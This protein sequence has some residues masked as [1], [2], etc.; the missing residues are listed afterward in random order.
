MPLLTQ[1][2]VK[3]IIL[4]YIGGSKI[5]G[6]GAGLVA[7]AGREVIVKS[8]PLFSLIDK[9]RGIV[10][11]A[12]VFRDTLLKN[13]QSAAIASTVGFISDLKTK[14]NNP[15]ISPAIQTQLLTKLAA[16]E[17]EV[18]NFQLHTDIL[19]GTTIPNVFEPLE[20]S[21]TDA[22]TATANALAYSISANS[23]A[24]SAAASSLLAAGFANVATSESSSASGY[25]YSSSLSAASANTSAVSANNSSVI[26]ASFATNANTSAG[27]SNTSANAAALSATQASANATSSQASANNSLNSSYSANTS[28]AQSA[29]NAV[30]SQTSATNA[31]TSA[32]NSATSSTQAATFAN[33]A[34]TSAG[35]AAS[36][37]TA[38]ATSASQA[39]ANATS[40]NASAN[41]SLNSSLAA[42]TSAGN[43]ATSATQSAANA[44]SSQTSSTNANT[45]AAN[46][47]T[48]SS[49]AAT[50]ATNA[51]TSAN[52]AATSAGAAATSASQASANATSSQASANNS[53]NSSFASNTSAGLANT[54]AANANTSANNAAISATQSASSATASA[55]SASQASANATSAN[56]SANNSLNSSLAANTS[57]GNANTSAGQAAANAT[58]SQTSATNANT[59]ASNASTSSS[60]SATY[61]TA[62]QASLV[63]T[64]PQSF[65]PGNLSAF[66]YNGTV[67]TI[68]GP[69]SSWPEPYALQWTDSSIQY[70]TPKNGI[71]R[72]AG[73]RY[74][75]TTIIYSYSNTCRA[76]IYLGSNDNID[77]ASGFTGYNG[78][79]GTY[80]PGVTASDLSPIP[81]NTFYQIGLDITVG[82][83]AKG[84]ITPQLYVNPIEAGT[85]T[86][87]G[88]TQTYIW[89]I[90]IQ[91]ITGE[92]ASAAS[93]SSSSASAALANNSAASANSSAILATSFVGSGNFLQNTD[94]P[95][96]DYTG[97]IL[98]YTGGVTTDQVGV[99]QPAAIWTPTGESTLSFRQSNRV[100]STNAYCDWHSHSIAV[101][102]LKYYQAYAYI[103]GHRC[104]V[105]LYA[106]FWTAADAFLQTFDS[107]IIT[108]DT[109]GQNLSRF[110]KV[111]LPSF[112]A[113]SGAAYAQ[114][115]IRKQDTLAGN[116]DSYMW[117]T[118]PY[119]GTARS[120]QTSYNNYAP[121]SGK[122]VAAVS[123]ASIATNSSS[124]ST[125]NGS[126]ATI[127]QR[128]VAG[129]PNLVPNSSFEDGFDQWTPNP[130]FVVTS[131]G[132][133]SQAIT[134]GSISGALFGLGTKL[135]PIFGG[136]YYTT[137]ADM[138]LFSSSS[139][140]YCYFD[141]QYYAS[142]GTTILLDGGQTLRYASFDFSNDNARRQSWA[143]TELA[144][145]AAYYAGVRFIVDPAGG[146]ISAAAI[147]RVKLELSTTASGYSQEAT[148][149]YQA[150]VLSDHT[151]KLKSYLALSTTAGSAAASVKLMS[152]F[153]NGVAT[154]SVGIEAQEIVV[155]NSYGDLKKVAVTFSG[156]NAQ[157]NGDIILGGRIL[158]PNGLA[159]KLA[160]APYTLNVKDGQ[161][162]TY[163]NT[164]YL[165]ATSFSTIGLAPIASNETYSLY[166]ES[167]TFSGATVRLKISVPAV[168]SNNSVTTGGTTA[169]D[170]GGVQIYLQGLASATNGSYLM[171]G[172]VNIGAN[173]SYTDP[174][175]QA[176]FSI[177][178]DIFAYVSGAWTK[179]ATYT[180]FQTEYYQTGGAKT[181][182]YPWSI[183]ATA[184]SG[185]TYL[186]AGSNSN[187]I[188]VGGNVTVISSVAW[189]SQ[190][191]GSSVRSAS[192]N[193]TETC[194]LTLTYN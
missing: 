76:A 156:G 79:G 35:N 18:A 133:G 152:Q 175:H 181:M 127:N 169:R 130:Q 155:T 137:T 28:A 166:L 80:P 55:T 116:T 83:D 9:L 48:S 64:I 52:N 173:A 183:T 185:V 161:S 68:T 39:S 97:W 121:G 189:T 131:N 190:G 157:F 160:V 3:K 69:S 94:F 12:G 92:T 44:T 178:F 13:P 88:G 15:A 188:S 104:Q 193:G 17:T 148:A 42:N 82:S 149:Q 114:V 110:T 4:Q 153:A 151:G 38:S 194:Q 19:S 37:A 117:F 177:Y 184:P 22:V 124:I 145:A 49:Q 53:L 26:A 93:A 10:G 107:G 125:I 72:I 74:R 140:T 77:N 154:S 101:E 41:N 159:L 142:D 102:E 57:A 134:T 179:I 174:S 170:G 192:P 141:V 20:R 165:P 158:F 136:N 59:S 2:V 27:Q 43:A 31:N 70:F 46:A 139:S 126:I 132:W 171:Q 129:S 40:A 6:A 33:N 21:F 50:F 56:A 115:W 75:V 113:P 78:T 86:S 85:N 172:S 51:N 65:A 112:Q 122:Q 47:A 147:R 25:A 29:A 61:S 95:N 7:G 135:I 123:S 87:G 168:P 11:Q 138:A 84:F 108:P 146:T 186:G 120:G 109:G 180:D 144:P 63:A 45:S 73:R 1:E 98:S 14:L 111:G 81:A 5:S 23:S 143:M 58:S 60:Q 164:G 105:E 99:G 32:A 36:S 167:Q 103:A 34:N 90:H 191:T 30:S 162:I 54:S 62:S 176:D 16:V 163:P 106:I 128:L 96:G 71:P 89:G 91:D 8:Q 119:F 24:V 100:G 67:A 150:G 66:I 118:R 187:N 182:T